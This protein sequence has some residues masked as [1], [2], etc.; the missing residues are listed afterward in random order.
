MEEGHGALGK[1]KD[2]DIAGGD[3]E[4]LRHLGDKAIELRNDG[5]QAAFVAEGPAGVAEPLAAEAIGRGGGGVGRID[6]QTF[7]KVTEACTQRCGEGD[8][9]VAR[10]TKAV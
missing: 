7:A 9:V 8:K 10:G 4:G 1:T 5:L 3:G 2:G 6:G